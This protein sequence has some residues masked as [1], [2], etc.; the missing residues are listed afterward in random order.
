MQQQKMIIGNNV[1]PPNVEDIE[2]RII[3]LPNL[4]SPWLFY[5]YIK[6][7]QSD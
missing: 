6:N 1:P 5:E 7:G 3:N 2:R 4:K